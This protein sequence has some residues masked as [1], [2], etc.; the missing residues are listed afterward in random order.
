MLTLVFWLMAWLFIAFLVA[1]A[2]GPLVWDR[3]D[4]R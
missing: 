3:R 2:L 1:L 4:E